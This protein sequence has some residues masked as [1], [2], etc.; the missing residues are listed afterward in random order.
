MWRGLR[1]FYQGFYNLSIPMVG[2]WGPNTAGEQVT[3]G[4]TCFIAADLWSSA[5]HCLL[6][7]HSLLCCVCVPYSGCRAP[8]K[9][10]NRGKTDLCR[11]S[12][13][14]RILFLRT[15]PREINSLGVPVLA[16]LQPYRVVHQRPCHLHA[17]NCKHIVVGLP[18]KAP[19]IQLL[20][21]P[22]VP[23]PEAPGRFYAA[24][25]SLGVTPRV[26]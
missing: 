15:R 7:H 22:R 3:S 4:D 8:C 26:P 16:S 23:E 19:V 13:A 18:H 12:T 24:K 9:L 11:S 17:S 2:W 6:L 14:I 21:T 1:P 5:C 20:L 10:L 25:A